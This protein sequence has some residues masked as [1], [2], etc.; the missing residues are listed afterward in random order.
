MQDFSRLVQMLDIMHIEGG[1]AV[2]PTDLPA[3]TRHL[4]CTSPSRP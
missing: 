4:D 1:G 3:E 2:E